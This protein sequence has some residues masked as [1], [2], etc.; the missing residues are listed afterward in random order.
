MGVLQDPECARQWFTHLSPVYEPVVTTAFWPRSLQREILDMVDIGG[1]DH[2]LDV[3]C[4]SGV[5]TELLAR[6]AGVVDAL[7]LS[8]PQLRRARTK[9]YDVP[10][11]F[12]RG[13]AEHLPYVDDTFDVTVAVGAIPYFPNPTV[14]LAECHRVTHPG[15]QIVV[16]GLNAPSVLSLHPFEQW[17]ATAGSVYYATYDE[18]EADQLFE[19][20]GWTNVESCITGPEWCPRLAVV[21]TAEKS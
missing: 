17:I 19:D 10:T 7:D 13:D 5:T 9:Q 12:V 21:T 6:R 1:E 3:G 4:G 18:T 14:A 16:A 20:A 8:S 11:R 2:V 15:G